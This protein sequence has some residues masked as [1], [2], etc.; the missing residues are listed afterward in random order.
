MIG[1]CREPWIVKVMRQRG[2]VEL[3]IGREGEDKRLAVCALMIVIEA[4][5]V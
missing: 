5:V 4:M 3:R 1:Q 2:K